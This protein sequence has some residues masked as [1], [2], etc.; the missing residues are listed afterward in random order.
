MIN[1]AEREKSLYYESRNQHL[2]SFR[3]RDILNLE[4]IKFGRFNIYYFLSDELLNQN[5]LVKDLFLKSRERALADGVHATSDSKI[6]KIGHR[7]SPNYYS[8]YLEEKVVRKTVYDQL[9]YGLE[10][11]LKLKDNSIKKLSHAVSRTGEVL[12]D[13]AKVNLLCESVPIVG[14]ECAQ[15]YTN[16]IIWDY[17]LVDS[18]HQKALLNRLKK[19]F[20]G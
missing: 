13:T 1:S 15:K 6:M 18:I 2:V 14:V 19:K 10:F 9:I 20:G 17:K 11:E 8:V 3:P 5:N 16:T 7:K 12:V 4:K